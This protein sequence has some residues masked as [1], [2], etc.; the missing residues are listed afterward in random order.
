M[1][2]QFIKNSNLQQNLMYSYEITDFPNGSDHQI[3]HSHQKIAW[4]CLKFMSKEN[5]WRFV[6]SCYENNNFQNQTIL[7]VPNALKN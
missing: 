4:N 7:N 1:G 3:K 5:V 6:K 2:I